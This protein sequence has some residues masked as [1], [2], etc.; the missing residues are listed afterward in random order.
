M[1]KILVATDFSAVALNAANYASDMALAI[2]ADIIL[3][4]VFQIPVSY[5]EIP[6]MMN[7]G[8]MW[9][10]AEKNMKELKQFLGSKKQGRLTIQTEVRE[11]NFFKEL[12]TVCENINPH[13]VVMG[14]QGTTAAN[15]FFFGSNAVYAMKHLIW[16]LITVPDCAVFC[17]VKKIGLACDLNSVTD[18]TPVQD[19]EMLIADFNAELHILNTGKQEEYNPD[20]VFQSGLLR[21]MLNKLKP[22]Y[23]FITNKNTDEGILDFAEKNHIDLLIV[24]PKR[25]GLLDKLIHKSHTKHFVLHSHIPVMALHNDLF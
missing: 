20:V 14:S 25:H 10:D 13:T 16:P 17:G 18:T 9:Q 11:G 19:I 24:L 12:K 21:E 8:N 3:L 7:E 2:N 1:K 4:H 5:G 6:L 15:R 22:D 23:H